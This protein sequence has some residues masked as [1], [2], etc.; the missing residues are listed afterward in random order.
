MEAIRDGRDIIGSPV[1][2]SSVQIPNLP[3]GAS[4]PRVALSVTRAPTTAAAVTSARRRTTVPILSCIVFLWGCAPAGPAP[5]VSDHASA[6]KA[7][8]L[9][10]DGF[11]DPVGVPEGSLREAARATMLVA[12]ER[13]W[14]GAPTL[15]WTRD[16]VQ[17]ATRPAREQYDLCPDV[18]FGDEPSVDFPWVGSAALVGSRL[19]AM[20]GHSI[21]LLQGEHDG[22]ADIKLL[23]GYALRPGVG[24]RDATAVERQD[25]YSCARVLARRY[26]A[27][28]I[29]G[30]P[31]FDQT[32]DYALIELD[33]PVQGREPLTLGPVPEVGDEVVAI[34]HPSGLPMKLSSRG[35]VRNTSS[36]FLF[37]ASVD[38]MRGS[39]GGPVVDERGRWIG[40][41]AAGNGSYERAPEGCQVP[42]RAVPCHDDEPCGIYATRAHAMED[43]IAA[44][45]EAG[46]EVRSYLRGQLDDNPQSSFQ[47]SHS[48]TRGVP[49]EGHEALD[50]P[51]VVD[52]EAGP[53]LAATVHA[54]LIGASPQGVTI[55][56]LHDGRSSGPLPIEGLLHD[57]LSVLQTAPRFA[58]EPVTGSWRLL[59]HGTSAEQVS[60]T[61]YRLTLVTAGH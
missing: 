26:T 17:L 7:D 33:R 40:L 44:N 46:L 15:D 36:G 19:V 18:P 28:G 31:P 1:L 9:D 50:V 51:V 30:L 22:C 11:V 16:T 25:R 59:V 48:P 41:V 57:R 42:R 13:H 52:A 20:A 43:L 37:A 3:T 54:T 14:D 61:G 10:G 39:S 29:P 38:A 4:L 45:E 12:L 6:G 24:A 35:K 27:S 53:V 32:E 58:G 34:G 8:F 21:S 55:E 47:A 49:D 2:V 60:L 5:D 23:F 56:L